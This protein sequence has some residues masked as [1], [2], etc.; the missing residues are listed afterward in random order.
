MKAFPLIASSMN[1]SEISYLTLSKLIVENTSTLVS[2]NVTVSLIN[3][4]I[5]IY[6]LVHYR[7]YTIS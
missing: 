3:E 6:G 1:R 7:I 4:L 2:K 5:N